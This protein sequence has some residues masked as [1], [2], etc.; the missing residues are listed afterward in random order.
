MYN[1]I[2]KYVAAPLA[3]LALLAGVYGCEKTNEPSQVS[4]PFRKGVIENPGE[5]LYVG[6]IPELSSIGAIAAAD[7]D[8]D[9]DM[10]VVAVSRGGDL[11]II[12]NTIPQEKRE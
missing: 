3:G 8:G 5:I 10:D 11:Y 9:G 6:N 2:K 12:F 1:T 4:I 7:M